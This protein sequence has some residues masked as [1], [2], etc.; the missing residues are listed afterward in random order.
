MGRLGV[1]GL[2]A[3]GETAGFERALGPRPFDLPADHGAHHGFRQEWWYLTGNLTAADGTAYGYQLTLFR[4]ALRPLIVEEAPRRSAWAA[5]EV[6]MGH[7]ALADQAS[8]RFYAYERFSRAAAGLAGATPADAPSALQ[9]RVWVNGWTIVLGSGPRTSTV[10][11]SPV[12]GEASLGVHAAA[13][14][15]DVALELTLTSE[16]PPVLQGDRGWSPKG[17]APGNA[18]YYYSATRMA[19]RGRLSVAGRPREVTGSSW[20]DREWSTSALGGDQAGWDWFALQLDDGREL[21]FYRLRRRDGTTDRW[22]AGTLV[23]PD[24]ATQVVSPQELTVEV[25]AQWASPRDGTRYPA[26]WRLR[27]TALKLDLEV[28][29]LLAD[30]ELPLAVR[31]WEGAVRVQGSSLGRAVRGVGYVELTGYAPPSGEGPVA[32]PTAPGSSN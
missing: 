7:F 18:S 28:A 24:G 17:A 21:M 27:S 13:A 20:L 11:A 22:S 2:L 31:Y 6:Y 23:A 16:K 19:T 10:A 1:T 4:S 32:A 26:R 30:Q 15:G 3:G 5:R 29:P 14:Q 9:R 12:A 8:G 25:L